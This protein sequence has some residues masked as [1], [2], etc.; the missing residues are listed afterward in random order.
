MV[1][2]WES[3]SPGYTGRCRAG[4]GIRIIRFPA[5]GAPAR[6]T[7]PAEPS[8]I[9]PQVHIWVSQAPKLACLASALSIMERQGAPVRGA[10]RGSDSTA[11]GPKTASLGSWRRVRRDVR[12]RAA[13]KKRRHRRPPFRGGPGKVPG[14][15]SG[16]TVSPG[17]SAFSRLAIEGGS[18]AC[19]G[20][21]VSTLGGA[22]I[23]LVLVRQG[24]APSTRPICFCF[25][26]FLEVPPL[27]FV[28]PFS[29]RRALDWALDRQR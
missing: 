15:I 23:L 20:F 26:T 19:T 5:K 3:A 27:H 2:T 10:V 24:R 8:S 25:C 14:Q 28:P 11:S 1:K 4:R 29:G 13:P 22:P 18:G 6:S 21:G 7:P 16:P 9:R 12:R 17:K